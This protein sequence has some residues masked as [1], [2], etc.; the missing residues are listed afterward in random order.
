M[1]VFLE[2]KITVHAIWREIS[3]LWAILITVRLLKFSGLSA[4]NAETH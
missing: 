2:R 1:E 4:V 3:L